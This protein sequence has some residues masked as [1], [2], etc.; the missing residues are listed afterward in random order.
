MK[1]LAMILGA[2]LL[3]AFTADVSVAYTTAPASAYVLCK[4][5]KAGKPGHLVMRPVHCKKNEVLITPADYPQFVGPQGEIGL[6]GPMGPQGPAGE[7]GLAGEV[8][9][10]GPMGLTGPVGP[11][12]EMGPMG[13]I[14]ETGLT[15][16]QGPTG[17]Q[18]ETG[19]T[20][21]AGPQGLQGEVGPVGPAGAKGEVGAVGPMGPGGPAGPAG[22]KGDSIVGPIGPVGPAGPQGE[23]GPTGPAG[24]AGEPGAPGSALAARIVDTP[25][26][27]SPQVAVGA[28]GTKVAIE[29]AVLPTVT[30]RVTFNSPL[31]PATGCDVSACVYMATFS[32][33]VTK[34]GN[35]HRAASSL[36]VEAAPDDPASVDV[37]VDFTNVLTVV[38]SLEALCP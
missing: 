17:P 14:G 16:P 28:A 26:T 37:D 9:L 20:G 3:V 8:G 31:C 12:G 33:L 22:P 6:I 24:A 36:V 10:P 29:S 18:G 19:L 25:A 7:N 21:A 5:K 13:P 4:R 34:S 27:L 32:G 23:V 1:R 11:Q 2:A 38:F 15:G 35:P 30:Y